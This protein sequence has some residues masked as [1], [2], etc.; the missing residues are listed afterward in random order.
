MEWLNVEFPG[1]LYGCAP[2]S[3]RRVS[4]FSYG[5]ELLSRNRGACSDRTAK[6]D[7][8]RV[9]Y[10]TQ[11]QK[12]LQRIQRTHLLRRKLP[13]SKV[14]VVEHGRKV[15]PPSPEEVTIGRAVAV[16]GWTGLVVPN[17]VDISASTALGLRKDPSVEIC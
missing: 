10:W 3:A 13:L 5:L 16:E 14:S 17:V 15:S 8:W 1:F 12:R 11:L 6:F 2:W 7:Y 4:P 9:H